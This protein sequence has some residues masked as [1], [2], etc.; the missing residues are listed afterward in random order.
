MGSS[1]LNL[2]VCYSLLSIIPL[3]LFSAFSIVICTQEGGRYQNKD[4]CNID[5]YTIEPASAENSDLFDV[6]E[7]SLNKDRLTHD[8]TTDSGTFISIVLMLRGKLNRFKYTNS[9]CQNDP[10]IDRPCNCGVFTSKN[11]SS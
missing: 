9:S 6:I 3:L 4:L 11:S 1:I 2:G 5:R 10:T 8:H 7:A